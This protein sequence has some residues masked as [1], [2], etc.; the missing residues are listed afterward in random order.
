MSNS[1]TDLIEA[2][3]AELREFARERDW[4]R[5]H[6]LRNLSA[7]VASEAGEL[8]AL[9]RWGEEPSKEAKRLVEDEVA[10]VFMAI[11]RFADVAGID[12]DEACHAKLVKN[13][14]KYPP[15]RSDPHRI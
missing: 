11:L 3:Q 14:A 13:A 2:L 6:T 1:R 12:L 7:L 10:D 5:Y 9:Y 8:L 4:E 15:G